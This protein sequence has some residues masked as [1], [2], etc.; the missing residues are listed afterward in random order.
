M[1]YVPFQDARCAVPP[2][3]HH[4]H[5]THAHSFHTPSYDRPAH[6]RPIFDRPTYDRPSFNRPSFD[7]PSFDRPSFDRPS[8][9]RPSYDR[10]SFDR[11]SFDRPSYNLSPHDRPIYDRPPPDRPPQDRWNPHLRVN[12]GNQ[13]YMLDQEEVHP[14][15]MRERRSESHRNKLLRRTVSVPVE[16]RHHPEMD[17]RARRKSI[18]TGKQPS[19]EVP[20]TAPIQPFRQSVSNPHCSR[21]RSLPPSLSLSLL[22]LPA[23]GPP[24]TCGHR[25][26]TP[27]H[28][29]PLSLL[30]SPSLSLCE[31]QQQ[32]GS[33]KGSGTP[34]LPRSLPL[35]PSLSFTLPHSPAALSSSSSPLFSYWGGDWRAASS[36]PVA[37]RTF[38]APLPPVESFLSRRL[39]GSIKRAK[40]QP[41]LD[42]TSSFRH[43]IL[44]R[45]RSADQDRTRLMQS[46]K[47]SHSHE[48][49]LSPSSAAEALDL[50]LD[51][52][53]V[54]KPVH[55]SILGQ[56]YCFEVTT[57]SG[58]KCFACRSA[59][60][61]DKW[62]ENLQRAVKPNKDNSRRVDNVLKLWIIEARELPAKKRYYCE[63]CLDDMLY[64]RTTSKPRTD[65]VF[66][67]E[68]FEFNNLPAVRNLR[69][70][71]YKETDKKR[72]KEKS[73]YLGLVSIPISSITGRQ[74][75]EQWYPVIQ[76]SVLTKGAGG[77]GGKIINASLRLKSRFQTM[78]ILP[79]ELYKEFAEYVTNNYRTLCAVLEPVLSVKSKEE[80]A[81]ALVH[82]LQSTGKAKDFLSD[83]AMCEVDRF[84]D[85]EHLIFRE[86]T[87][88]TKAIEEYLKLIGHKYLKDAIG[89]F[90]RALYESEENCEV[91]PMRTPPSVLPDHQANLRMCCELALCKIVNS[92]CV[93]PRELKE[94][95]AS[96][97]VRCAERGREDIADR[98]ISGSLFLR[99]L[100]P[101]IMSPSLFNL[102]Q[103]Y[104]DE[105]TSRTLT[106]IAKV[107]QNLA[108]FS[109][110]GNKE[111]YMCFMN[112]FLEME[113]GSMQQFLYEISNVDSV[114]NAGGFEGYIDLGRELS[115][116]HSLLWEVIAQLSKQNSAKLVFFEPQ[117]AIIKLGPLPRL[118]NDISMALRNPHL[119]RQ[120][121]HQTDRVQ[122]RQTDRL[123]SRPSFN[124]G[125]SSEF[126]NL[127]MRDL[128]SSIDITR[129]PSPTSTGGVMPSRSQMGFQDRDQLHRASSK[130]MFYVSRPPLARS[131]P[132]YCTSSSDITEPDPKASIAGMGSFG[133]LS[134][135]GGGGLGS[136]LSSQLRAGGRLSAGS[137]GSS[138][139]GGLRLSQLSQMGTT[140]DSLSQQQQQQAAAM[141][142]P[143]SFQN[144]L[145][146]L[147]TADGPQQQQLHH[148]HSR[149]QPPAPLLLAPEPDPSHP[150]YMPQFAHGGFS[151][152]EDLSTLR[153][154][155]NHLGQPSII[156]SHS[157]SD[158]YSRAEYGR[159]QMS[160][161]VQDNLQ[162]Q[163]QMMGLASQ[164]GTSHSSLA[165][166]PP[167][168][169]QPVRQSSVA[170]PPIQ[171][172]KSQTSHQLSVS[173][174]A[175]P[176]ALAKTRPPSGN[177]LQSPES[178]YGGRQHGSRQL[179]VKDNTAPGLPHQQSSVRESQSPQGTTSQSTQ[180]SP[181][182]QPQQQHLLKPTMSKQGSQTPSTLNPPTPANERTVAWVSNMP[183]LSADIES[184]RID[185]EE[186]KLKEYSKSMDE[187][188]MDRVREYEEE[189][190]SLKDRLVMSHKKLEEYERRLLTQE[191]QTNK[192]LLQYQNRLDDS[193]RKLRQQQVEKDSQIKGIISRLM[194]V[195]DELRGGP[196]IEP[197]TRIFPDQEEQLSSLGYADPGV[198]TEGGG[199]GG[200]GGGGAVINDQGLRV[201]SSGISSDSSPHN[202]VL[203]QTVEPPS[204]PTPHQ[205]PSQNGELRGNQTSSPM[206]TSQAT[207]TTATATTGIAEEGGVGQTQR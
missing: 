62:I 111:E 64:A 89:E 206:T 19:M 102:T 149:A 157:Y 182:Q 166:T 48:S 207:G 35:S 201:S 154:R 9:D 142:Y 55:S 203:P 88:A 101:A 175:A 123:L 66:W 3:Y 163:Q 42:R 82:I 6:E 107:V 118:L 204:L 186:F 161:H 72:R 124:R 173:A 155:D 65:T 11:P 87:L 158:D 68:H 152:S 50:T 63:L 145:F 84:I 99:F 147:A 156:H 192:I 144:P 143:L 8:F 16:G 180:Q 61:R 7:R 78:N 183:H 34:P 43:M 193:E 81:C 90:I 197:K 187:S 76:P 71:L 151:R 79:M 126:Q 120:P 10:P 134:S 115:I 146:H 139:S 160:T 109:K 122:E 86:N 40:S 132:A 56:E 28:P 113:W 95:F 202:G 170:P 172:V 54:I 32:K 117:D 100:C 36:S 2:S 185:R 60:E 114:S 97:R 174:A 159:R 110:F 177:L 130:D 140:T 184:S 59:A 191:Q 14:L 98:L 96:W 176:A 136:G 23:L 47:E 12:T 77:G 39:K 190:N 49:L 196:V 198:K 91:D 15:L 83:M 104:P 93:F 25:A 38:I 205:H 53:A 67:G 70:H 29:F 37:G 80:V 108:N 137:G 131:S 195:E 27:L 33:K 194:A 44:P 148:Q 162:Q 127:M 106:L 128:N 133:G 24:H 171:R 45:F 135:G 85:R 73:T 22:P 116:L 164:T 5:R 58:T 13:I 138:M 121:S 18:A 141:R 46:F 69:L 30:I 168:T 112:E 75:V 57:A 1:S 189:I 52:D 74:F 21:P 20:P 200:G 31:Q 178:G 188:R 17:H 179:S 129:L 94:V 150:T 119:Q 165:T 181:Q 199:G 103:E 26:S 51:E 125:I 92:H 167:T 41:K 169:V 4:H 153:T 105:Q